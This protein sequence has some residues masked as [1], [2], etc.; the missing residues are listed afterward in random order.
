[1]DAG[2]QTRLSP[3]SKGWRE[4]YT[5]WR[6]CSCPPEPGSLRSNCERSAPG[7]QLQ[8]G[9]LCTSTLLS[10]LPAFQETESNSILHLVDFFFFFK[11]CLRSVGFF[12]LLFTFTV[13]KSMQGNCLTFECLPT[14]KM[15][16]KYSILRSF[17]YISETWK[18]SYS[19]LS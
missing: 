4:Q 7:P 14:G 19:Y 13:F 3:S 2:R 9:P 16:D 17:L 10:A 18:K 6:T 12:F 1:M 15:S 8:R 11:I 5:S